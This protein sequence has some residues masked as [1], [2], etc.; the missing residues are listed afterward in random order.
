MAP[1]PAARGRVV[2]SA[3]TSRASTAT[4]VQTSA[5]ASSSSA[6]TCRRS[7]FPFYSLGRTRHRGRARGAAT[8]RADDAGT[9]YRGRRFDVVVN[10]SSCCRI[11]H[12]REPDS[13]VPWSARS[14]RPHG[15]GI[16]IDFLPVEAKPVLN[17]H[18][19]LPQ[20]LTHEAIVT[21]FVLLPLGLPPSA[22]LQLVAL[23][24]TWQGG[25]ARRCGAPHLARVFL[26][27]RGAFRACCRPLT[28]RAQEPA[29]SASLR[30]FRPSFAARDRASGGARR[31]RHLPSTVAGPQG[32]LSI[33]APAPGTRGAKCCRVCTSGSRRRPSRLRGPAAGARRAARPLGNPRLRRR[34]WNWTGGP[35]DNAPF[36][37]IA[38][39]CAACRS[40]SPQIL[41]HEGENRPPFSAA[42]Q[43]RT[44]LAL[45]CR[46]V[47]API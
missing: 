37:A 22:A 11:S 33:G 2:G 16:R 15:Q 31:Q 41:P 28:I 34:R 43:A 39:R 36:N 23:M 47:A 18:P 7:L 3:S 26:V 8:T 42:S 5:S 35:E 14:R 20:S 45:C 10:G 21:P 1:S 38:R 44:G 29:S 40:A 30:E 46:L 19:H 17:A 4:P 25:D 13:P 32:R 27:Q 9:R 6:P 12:R 24:S